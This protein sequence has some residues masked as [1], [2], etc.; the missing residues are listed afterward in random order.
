[1][2]ARTREIKGRIKA[3]GNIE[4]ITKTMQ[5]I[6]TARF[7]AMQKRATSAQAYTR[8]IAQLVGEL[9]R[10]AGS[11]QMEHPLL[12]APAEPV[13]RRLLLVIT[14][15][16]GLCGAYNANILRQAM[17]FIREHEG[18]QLDVEAVG[19]K[20]VN[21][22]RFNR[23]E[24]AQF[25]GH[26][27]DTPRYEDVEALATAYMGDFEA[28]RYDGVHVAFTEF[29][30]MSRQEAKVVRLLPAEDPTGAGE[31]DPGS[32][33]G[34]T[35]QYEF[36]PEPAELLADLLPITVKT[37][38]FQCL[39]ESVVSEQISRMVAMK[40]ATDAAGKMK[41]GLQ[42]SFNRARQTAITTELS[43]IIGGAAAL[44]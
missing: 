24:V 13:G 3:V 14:S 4:R 9:S 26:I 17:R 35:V 31:G 25:H 7:Q 8:R 21:F 36:T 38:L 18:E 30:S 2:P 33:G 22:M 32:A 39:N 6:A 29:H 20:A 16:R 1:M 11:E 41:K 10:G 27:G 43:E 28:G 34:P 5:M 19:K 44:E 12:A 23:V 42:R 37:R 40:A 15:N